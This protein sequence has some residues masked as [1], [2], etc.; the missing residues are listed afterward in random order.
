MAVFK[1]KT[2][3][4]ILQCPPGSGKNCA[5]FGVLRVGGAG[6]QVDAAPQVARGR[7]F[8]GWGSAC[9]TMT[10]A[11]AVPQ[12][13]GGNSMPDR[14]ENACARPVSCPLPQDLAFVGL[15]P[16]LLKDFTMSTG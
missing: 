1:R 7:Q 12:S 9:A 2:G 11:S 4:A 8:A 14:V 10:L 16:M 13:S 5:A 6:A 15:Q 3:A